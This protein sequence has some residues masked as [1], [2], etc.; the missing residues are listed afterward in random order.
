MDFNESN[1]PSVDRLVTLYDTLKSLGILP[2]ELERDASVLS[3]IKSFNSLFKDQ[4]WVL[5]NY[6][7]LAC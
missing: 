4:A 2:T 1:N 7:P 6:L 3:V 5:N